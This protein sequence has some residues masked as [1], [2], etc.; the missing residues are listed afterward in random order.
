MNGDA[1]EVVHPERADEAGRVCRP[2][3]MGPRGVGVE[4]RVID[5]Q[6]AASLEEVAECLRP[7]F[8]LEGVLP[9][10]QLPGQLAPL[11][12]QLV[13]QPGELL[14]LRQ[15]PLPCLEPLVVLHHLMGCHVTPPSQALLAKRRVGRPTA[16]TFPLGPPPRTSQ[17][18]RLSASRKGSILTDDLGLCPTH[19]SI[20]VTR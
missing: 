1:V 18:R 2:G 14:L 8:T 20:L 13:A 9:F 4:H 3:R 7:V 19:A 10:D 15:V 17:D 5:D 6:L 16:L 12:A 11:P